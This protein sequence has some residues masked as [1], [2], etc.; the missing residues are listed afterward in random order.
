MIRVLVV[1]DQ[2]MYR[3][4]LR[5]IL[6]AERDVTVVGEAADGD[7]ALVRA[8]ATQPDVVLMDVRMPNRNGIDATRLLTA[9][10]REGMRVPRIIVLTTFDIDDYVFD[11]VNAGASGFLLKDAT[12]AELVGAVRVVAAGEALL[13][14][15]ATRRLLE[16]YSTRPRAVLR[17]ATVLADLTD[18][19]REVFRLVAHGLSNAEIA[20]HLFIAEQTVKSHVSRILAKVGVR[21]RVH[22]VVLGYETGVVTPGAGPTPQ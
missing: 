19:E 13:A 22:A 16:E 14:P 21:D 7:E 3:V 18:R 4:G 2:E 20:E 5:A 12:P 8:R 6:E 9:P 15:S 17:P 11:A 10:A 1:D